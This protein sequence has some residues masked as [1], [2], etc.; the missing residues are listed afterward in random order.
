MK[1]F[2][3][4]LALTAFAGLLLGYG[5]SIAGAGQGKCQEL[6]Y[7]L[8]DSGSFNGSLS[9]RK[10]SGNFNLSEIVV[11]RAELECVCTNVFRG[12][13]NVFSVSRANS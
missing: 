8:R 6:E 3:L 10:P 5:L 7:Q 1:R 12:R 13:K 2:F 9:C 4:I 11:K